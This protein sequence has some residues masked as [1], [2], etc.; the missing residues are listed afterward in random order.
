MAEDGY[1]AIRLCCCGIPAARIRGYRQ[2]QNGGEIP[3]EPLGRIA[4]R[5]YDR[6]IER[7]LKELCKVRNA[8]KVAR[9]AF[10]YREIT[11][12][13]EM[14][15]IECDGSPSSAVYCKDRCC[16]VVAGTWSF[17]IFINAV[18]SICV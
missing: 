4:S 3:T 14:A 6:K 7:A 9:A 2:Q 12:L 1:C 17:R 11:G 16:L 13:P 8:A 15:A 18:P 10:A 5:Q